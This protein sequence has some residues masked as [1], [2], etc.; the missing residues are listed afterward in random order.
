ME[1]V[2]KSDT[3]AS[4]F[5]YNSY[6]G[7]KWVALGS[8]DLA[9]RGGSFSYQPP[10]NDSGLYFVRF[11]HKGGAR[12]RHH[13]AVGPSHK[14]E[15]IRRPIPGQRVRHIAWPA[16]L[17]RDEPGPSG[18]VVGGA[19]ISSPPRVPVLFVGCA[20]GRTRRM[21]SAS[22]SRRTSSSCSA[23]IRNASA[24]ALATASSRLWP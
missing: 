9:A 15:R 5:C 17:R 6:D 4:W 19:G 13:Q 22:S 23:R 14:P 24:S 11:T 1:I 16:R 20:P 18:R 8:G 12:R 3:D 10:K 7:A 21:P 2:N